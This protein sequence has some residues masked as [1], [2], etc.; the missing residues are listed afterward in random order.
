MYATEPVQIRKGAW[1]KSPSPFVRTLTS[2]R[3]QTH[4][5]SPAVAAVAVMAPFSEVFRP[6][7]TQSV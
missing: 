7:Y 5:L 4:S 3:S 2:W 6:E 1:G